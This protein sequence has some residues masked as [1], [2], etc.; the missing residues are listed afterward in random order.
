MRATISGNAKVAGFL[1]VVSGLWACALGA[2]SVLAQDYPTRPITGLY[3]AAAGGTVEQGLRVI[4]TEAGKHLG[5]PIV[6]EARPGANG[7]IAANAVRQARGNPHLLGFFNNGVTVTVP[8]VSGNKL[9]IGTDFVPV[10]VL[11]STNLVV[12]AHPSAP[13][14]DITG[15]IAY[16]KN[17]PGKLDMAVVG[18]ASNTHLALELLKFLSGADIRNIP[19]KGEAQAVPAV[20]AGDVLT[21]ITSS[22]AKPNVDAGRLRALATTGPE[23]WPAFPGVPALRESGYPDFS[24]FG[25]FGVA[26]PPGT[27]PEVVAKLHA[28]YMAALKNPAVRKTVTED[29][30]L[31]LIGTTPEEMANMIRR[32]R[33]RWEP[34]VRKAG[35]RIE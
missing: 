5:Q 7:M 19:Y 8:L 11:L 32:D 6:V 20:V 2:G 10:S 33:E 26:A 21:A 35:I 9:D 22:T 4:S 1:S 34:V 15:M 13:F 23:R 24:V 30:G 28:A 25:W 12:I 14:K 16:A 31:D 27:S 29:L 17:Y 18:T 3:I